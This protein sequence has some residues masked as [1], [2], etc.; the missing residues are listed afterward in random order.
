M[1]PSPAQDLP[2]VDANGG[3]RS[4]DRPAEG[5]IPLE[6]ELFR[7]LLESAPDAM[8]IVDPTGQIVLVNAQTERIFGYSRDELIG[9]PVELLV[10][11]RFRTDHDRHRTTYA[12]DPHTRSMG[13]G[14]ELF[15][16]RKDNSEFPVEISLSPLVTEDGTLVSSAIRDITERKRTEQ[17]ASRLAAVVESSH[18][19]IISMDLDGIVMSWNRGAEHLY[20]YTEAEMRSR[21]ISVL[22]PPGHEDEGPDFLRRVRSGDRVDDFETVRA[23]KDGTQ[24]DISLTVSPIREPNGKVIGASAIARDISLRLR[25][26]EQLRFLADHDA[27]TGTRNRRRFERDLGEQIA[28]ARR[29][30]EKAA[31]LLLDLDG[32]KG[33][34]DRYGHKCGDRALE[35][36]AAV[37]K[38]RLRETDVI[39]R[40]GGDE[41]AVLL[42]YA[43][44]DQA[45]K[46]AQDLQR[47]IADNAQVIVP[48]GRY[49]L[50]ASVGIA[51]IDADTEGDEA[52][53]AEADAAMYRDKAAA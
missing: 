31:L 42:P 17:E 10:P 23:R 2:S 29:Y 46:V 35:E 24:V 3:H 20:G 51:L 15:G 53:L 8:V 52:V 27:L 28:R 39:S 50:S 4:T 22:A 1:K 43:G 9:R 18:D 49:A 7:G 12:E 26:Q 21:S 33:I 38:G 41:F 14:L 19:A 47:V 32:F 48:D 40:I 5:S 11:D 13:A 16:R 45:Q 30:G 6:A 36:V 25:Y 37:L 34:N 44:A